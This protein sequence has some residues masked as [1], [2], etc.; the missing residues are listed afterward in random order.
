M[1]WSLPMTVK[2]DG[3]DRPIRNRCDYRVVLDVISALKDGDLTEEQRVKCALYIFYE[4]LDGIKDWQAAVDGMMS[5]INLGEEEEED[6]NKPQLMDWE[7]D[8]AQIAPPIS[9]TLGYSV[10][11]P[12]KYTHWYDFIGAYME[13]GECAFSTIVSIRHKRMKG[14]KLEKWER[15]FYNENRKLIDLPHKLT[16]E[17]QE[18]LDSDW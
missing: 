1:N 7:H 8:F 17:E 11:D 13:I 6:S 2:I 14:K 18:F 4:S 10:R 16:R 3:V 9:R 12:D 5:I 15:E